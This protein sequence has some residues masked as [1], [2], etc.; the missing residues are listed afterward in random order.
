MMRWNAMSSWTV[1]VTSTHMH[2]AGR[3]GALTKLVRN[4]PRDPIRD[5]IVEP[6]F[7]GS[8]L[9]PLQ[10]N[11]KST[12]APAAFVQTTTR[13]ISP[14]P[15]LSFLSPAKTKHGVGLG[16]RVGAGRRCPQPPRPL[17]P[18]VPRR[19]RCPG[20][21]REEAAQR[22]VFNVNMKAGLTACRPLL[23]R[24]PVAHCPGSLCH[25]LA[26]PF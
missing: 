14:L 25:R 13:R 19:S 20:T 1:V 24:E 23:P 9:G 22:S 16:Q 15:G 5:L 18:K 11:G 6:R 8:P 26:D 7:S 2:V 4:L 3:S 17:H 10:R 21:A 12:R